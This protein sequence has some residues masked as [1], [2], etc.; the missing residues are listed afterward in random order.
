MKRALPAAV[1]LLGLC[2]GSGSRAYMILHQNSDLTQPELYRPDSLGLMPTPGNPPEAITFVIADNVPFPEAARRGLLQWADVQ[3]A[4]VTFAD[5]GVHHFSGDWLTRVDTPDGFNTV[6]M[7][8][9]GWTLSDTVVAWTNV[10]SDSL[11]G[12]ILEADIYLNGQDFT[13]ANLGGAQDPPHSH[14]Y[15]LQNIVTHEAGHLL[16]LA[17][18]QILLSTMWPSA[19][20]GETHKRTLHDDDRDGL[21][22]LYPVSAA[23]YPA[24]SLWAIR[25]GACTF[26]ADDYSSYLPL[27]AGAGSQAFCLFGAGVLAGVGAGLNRD[28]SPLSPNPISGVALVSENLVS[29]TMDYTGLPTDA[30]DPTLTNAGPKT[31]ELFQGVFL[32]TAA[33]QLPV[34]MATVDKDRVMKGKTVTL[35]GSGSNDPEG[36]ALT[37]QW[38]V[39]DAPESASV[40]FDSP[41]AVGTAVK[42]RQPGIYIFDLVVND[43]TIDSLADSV[44]VTALPPP[45]PPDTLCGIGPA[46]G[47]EALGLLLLPGLLLLLARAWRKRPARS[48]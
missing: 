43:G 39:I 5:G 18:S 47:P 8:K 34:A 11:T 32:N 2:L 25:A 45:A 19:P 27:T 6:E 42:L 24:P 46:A 7:V 10:F 17:H 33:N 9:Q 30:Y 38:L 36:A 21:R 15:D 20:T 35:D 37:Y 23:D 44:I 48:G 1:L 31:G 13:W 40:A 26:S 29:A 4:A 12:E 22:Y 3:G 41:T 28:D 14:A 16:G